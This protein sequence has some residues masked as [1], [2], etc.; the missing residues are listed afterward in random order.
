M[1]R[2]LAHLNR[3]GVLL[4]WVKVGSRG[5]ES[6][7][8]AAVALAAMAAPTSGRVKL[9][10]ALQSFGRLKSVEQVPLSLVLLFLVEIV[11]RISDAMHQ[12]FHVSSRAEVS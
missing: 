12:P 2:R 11:S 3:T 1:A 10:H 6:L 7:A 9:H 8:R 5:R 4:G